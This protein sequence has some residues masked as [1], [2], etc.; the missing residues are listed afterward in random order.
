M[1]ILMEFH[2]ALDVV[3]TLQVNRGYASHTCG[4]VLTSFRL[5]KYQN[6]NV[7]ANFLT[8]NARSYQIQISYQMREFLKNK[9]FWEQ[10]LKK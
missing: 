3:F 5:L 8:A 4:R 6:E 9:T 1:Y 10:F 7:N 2:T